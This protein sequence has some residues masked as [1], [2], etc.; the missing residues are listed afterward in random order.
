MPVHGESW[1]DVPDGAEF[2]TYVL[3]YG[4]F[5]Q[6]K[7]GDTAARKTGVAVGDSVLDLAAVAGR[8]GEDFTPLVESGSLNPLLA[9]GRP[10]WRSVRERLT[11]W[12]RDPSY[13][14]VV[15]ANLIPRADVRLHLPF[16]P[17]DFVDFYSS[18]HHAR[19]VGRMFRAGGD[20]LPANWK[21]LPVGYHGRAGTIVP[22][23]TPVSRPRGQR[24]PGEGGSPAF[25]STRKLDFEA[26]VGFVVGVPSELGKPVGVDD[27]AEHVIGVCLV[28]DWSA[29]DFQGWE[30]KP[31]GPFLGKSFATSLSPWVVPLD[32]L[33][34]AWVAPEGPREET[35]AYLRCTGAW[36]LDLRLTVRLNGHPIAQPPFSTMYWTGAQQLAHLT[37]AGA[38]LRTG[39]LFAS[40]TV[41][42]PEPDQRGSLLELSWD[43]SD[44]ILLRD[45]S[46]RGYL[47]DGDEVSISATAP[48][49]DGS[50]MGLGEVTGRVRPST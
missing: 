22:S 15:M 16:E 14:P 39:D 42:G 10:V 36:G 9:A 3:P 5:S 12:L 6:T 8:L 49:P 27:F 17:A 28:N 20:S 19:S 18:E 43:G 29:R 2:G 37:V 1:L 48:G 35:F 25:G 7:R 47:N 13:R 34:H 44:P 46:Q 11:E 21:H 38:S 23:G 40:G 45:G 50:R 4:V 41:S 24:G 30:Y 32:A 31:L 26:E 33:D